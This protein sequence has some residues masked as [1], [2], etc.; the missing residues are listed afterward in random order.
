MKITGGG[1]VAVL[2]GAIVAAA[3][4][5]G[6]NWIAARELGPSGTG[7]VLSFAT[8]FTILLTVGKLGLDT[9]V[10]REAARAMAGVC[11][12]PLRFVLRWAALLAVPISIIVSGCL[13]IWA[14]PLGRF[15]ADDP[16]VDQVAVIRM[17]A[18]I[19]PFAVIGL[20]LLSAVRGT[21]DVVAFVVIEQIGKPVFRIV[22]AVALIVGGIASAFTLSLAWAVPTLVGF[23]ATVT[24]LRRVSRRWPHRVPSGPHAVVESRRGLWRFAGPRAVNQGVDIVSSSVGVVVLAAFSTAAETGLFGTAMRIALAGL[25]AYHAVRLLVSPAIAHAIAAGDGAGLRRIYESSNVLLIAMSWPV[26]LFVLGGAGWILGLFGGGFGSAAG[27]LQILVL[28]GMVMT[29]LGNMQTV[30]LMAGSSSAALGAT[31]VGFAVNLGTTILLLGSLGGV[32]AAVGW[33]AGAVAEAAVLLGVVR[34]MGLNPAGGATIGIAARTAIMFGPVAVLLA[35]SP[36]WW[37]GLV[38]YVGAGAVWF[39]WTRG[40]LVA[41]WRRLTERP[42][43]LVGEAGA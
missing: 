20:I 22:V 32:G 25:L 8:W 33:A 23:V 11:E 31:C 17:G 29:F 27:M 43:G 5:F 19:L 38:A 10:M 34:G 30:V 12:V 41:S 24:W 3:A 1:A 9:A 16:G 6:F 28:A 37:A 7:V 21:G 14:Q 2:V 18:L 39:G 42:D 15:L 35:V 40:A 4:G 36:W 13:W 26:Y